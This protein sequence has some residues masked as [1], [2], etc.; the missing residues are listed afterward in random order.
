MTDM[1]SVATSHISDIILWIVSTV[2][3]SFSFPRLNK[4]PCGWLG[5]F[6]TS[7]T[8]SLLRAD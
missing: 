7:A 3:R 8:R 1:V 2:T 5:S 6:K 4:N